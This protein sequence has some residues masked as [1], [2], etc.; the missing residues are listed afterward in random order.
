MLCKQLEHWLRG[1]YMTFQWKRKDKFCNIPL[2]GTSCCIVYK[3]AILCALYYESM[4]R[5]SEQ[6]REREREREDV[7][8]LQ[9]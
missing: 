1:M 9:I 7:P 2:T 4:E 5:E 8:S 3:Y 6:E